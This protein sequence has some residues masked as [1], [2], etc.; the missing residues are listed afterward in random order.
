[1]DYADLRRSWEEE[2]KRSF[3]GWDFS[4]LE[5]R[6]KEE[7]LPWDYRDILRKYLKPEYKLLDMGTG[8]GEFLLTLG[9]PY[10][11]TSVT[12][13]WEPNVKLCESRLAPLGICVR[14]VY[15]DDR[16]PFEDNTFDVI[17]NRHES[18]SAKEIGRIL[19]PGGIFVTQQVGGRND[20]SLSRWLI[21][22]FMPKFP[23]W[24]LG[25][26]SEELKHN[27]FEILNGKECFP[28]LRFFDIGA[29]VYFAKIIEWEFPDFSVDKCYA[30]LCALQQELEEKTCI[31]C[32]EHRFIIVSKNSK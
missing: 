2:E 21:K 18:Y 10:E 20:E 29:I 27:S 8:G 1:M 26:A 19:K 15:E 3:Q 5:D 24:T 28:L 7:P 23:H 9:H 32:Y 4:S 13:S 22:D 6:W 14:Q 11:N 31:E 12:E 17:I 25:F 16:L 30:E